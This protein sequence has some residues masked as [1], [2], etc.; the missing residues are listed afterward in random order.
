[1]KVMKQDH[2]AA[3]AW[4]TIK[5]YLAMVCVAWNSSRSGVIETIRISEF[6]AAEHVRGRYLFLVAEH[7]TQ[8]SG[9]APISILPSTYE[10]MKEFV[11]LRKLLAVPK[12]ENRDRLFVTINGEPYRSYNQQINV[13]MKAK[14]YPLVTTNS[15]RKATATGAQRLEVHVQQAC[16]SHMKHQL[17]TAIGHYRCRDQDTFIESEKAVELA[18]N[19]FRAWMLFRQDPFQII[20]QETQEFPSKEHV[21]QIFAAR[22]RR[23]DMV[24]TDS[25]YGEMKD[26]WLSAKAA[27]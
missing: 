18:Q 19:T 24:L 11:S 20:C 3:R 27:T 1:M 8:D 2:A 5:Q 7:K 25:T 16:S 23:P 15:I 26:V 14:G 4:N 10:I 12:K 17:D 22:L 9:P 6:D 13:W 21:Q